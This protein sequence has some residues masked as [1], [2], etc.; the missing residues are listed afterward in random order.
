MTLSLRR[1]ALTAGLLACTAAALTTLGCGGGKVMPLKSEAEFDSVVLQSARP[2][3]VDFYKGGCPTCI[4]LDGIMDKLAEEYRGRAVIAKV[5]LMSPVFVVLTPELKKRYDISYFPT[6][7]LFVN[8]Q[9]TKRW[10]IHY[11]TNDYRKALNEAIA[12]Q[13]GPPAVPR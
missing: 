10:V 13:Q 1:A 2:V 5:E 3:L 8:G 9:E 4:P 12:A 7:V 11:A 6:A